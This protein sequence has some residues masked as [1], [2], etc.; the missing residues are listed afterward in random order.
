MILKYYSNWIIP[1]SVIWII[2]YKI[3]SP[4]V[5]YFNPYYSL[6]VIC[7]GYVFFSLYLLFYKD[8]QFNSLFIVLFMIHYFP[9]HYMMS[10]TLIDYATE[11][12]VITFFLYTL[13]LGYIGK[14]VYTVYALDNHPKNIKEII[15]SIV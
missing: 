11:T 4:L 7:V 1:L 2:L 13:Y 6:I 14:D 12:L 9:L 10:I 8:Y 5:K 15:N 3:N